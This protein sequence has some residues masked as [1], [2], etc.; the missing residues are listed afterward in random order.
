ML[1]SEE[2]LVVGYL[3]IWPNFEWRPPLS[4]RWHLLWTINAP[5]SSIYPTQ[6]LPISCICGVYVSYMYLINWLDVYE[7]LG[8]LNSSL[9]VLWVFFECS[10]SVLWECS[11]C[12]LS[13]LWVFFECPLSG[14]WV[15]S[16]YFLSVL[17]VCSEFSL[18]DL[19]ICSECALSVLSVFYGC[20]LRSVSAISEYLLS[21][22]C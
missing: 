12:S 17:W 21:V 7:A 8:A 2:R 14:V 20:S 18:S 15:I 10:L 1:E 4:Q 11:E 9:S 13:F 3:N 6:L 16:E 19:R 22:L 5:T